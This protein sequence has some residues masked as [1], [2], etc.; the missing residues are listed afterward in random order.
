MKSRAQPGQ[1]SEGPGQ[2]SVGGGI[3]GTLFF[4]VGRRLQSGVTGA[5]MVVVG[6]MAL[7]P[8]E[9]PRQTELLQHGRTNR[10]LGRNPLLVG[11]EVGKR[12][13]GNVA[14]SEG[15]HSP[16]TPQ[17]SHHSDASGLF[18]ARPP[19]LNPP[20]ERPLNRAELATE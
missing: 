2:Q 13:D 6:N 18:S 3:A 8:G 4:P 9:Q 16:R 5:N 17:F 1:A 14:R 15:R 10:R 11:N 20:P 7:E 12:D 19:P